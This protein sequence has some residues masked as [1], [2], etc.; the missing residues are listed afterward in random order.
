E[1]YRLDSI[2][3]ISPIKTQYFNHNMYNRAGLIKELI[4]AAQSN[5][6]CRGLSPQA[7]HTMVLIPGG[8]GI[9]KSR[10]GWEARN[11]LQHAKNLATDIPLSHDL[12]HAL[13]K[14]LYIFV[15]FSND[16]NYNHR[17][18]RRYSASVRIGF[19][20]ALA[21]GLFGIESTLDSALDTFKEETFEIKSVLKKI[22]QLRHRDRSNNPSCTAIIIHLDEYPLYTDESSVFRKSWASAR[23]EFKKMLKEIGN[24]MRDDSMQI[25]FNFF[26]LPICTGTSAMDIHFLNKEYGRTMIQIE[27]L[28]IS[29]AKKMFFDKYEY[30]P[31]NP[32]SR[33]SVNALNSLNNHNKAANA[34]LGHSHISI[35]SKNLCDAV[36]GQPHF[37]VALYDTA[38]IPRFIDFLFSTNGLA[39]NY[40]WGSLLFSQANSAYGFSLYSNMLGCWKSPEEVHA[41]IAFAITRQPVQRS[42]ILTNQRK[43]EDIERDG[44]IHLSSV[45]ELESLYPDSFCVSEAT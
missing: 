6:N 27:A 39:T 36:W 30:D 3:N 16:S 21:S 40:D 34:M 14:P 37:R 5:C 31:T 32:S 10:A 22:L 38:F 9:G 8:P 43:I 42:F 41:V 28:D 23:D 35:L 15:D 33:K 20:V 7:Y 26:I 17:L 13:R 2:S 1:K 18:D 11:L 29:A 44:L 45:D 19:R 12:E 4:R 25:E 24:V